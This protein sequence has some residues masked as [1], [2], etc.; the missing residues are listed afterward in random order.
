MKRCH[1]SKKSTTLK[2]NSRCI[3]TGNG[4]ALTLRIK[5]GGFRGAGN[6]ILAG[7][8]RQASV[9]H[10]L[11]QDQTGQHKASNGWFR[12]G[13]YIVKCRV[14]DVESGHMVPAAARQVSARDSVSRG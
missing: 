9:P 5:A 1:E 3:I 14:A 8:R 11:E 6:G 2:S 13:S 4:R 7:T 12:N 10:D